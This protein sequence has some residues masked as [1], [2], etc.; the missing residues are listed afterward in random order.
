MPSINRG[1]N[2]AAFR[3]GNAH[4]STIANLKADD[5]LVK[6]ADSVGLRRLLEP[7]Y[8]NLPAIQVQCAHFHIPRGSGSL[9]TGKELLSRAVS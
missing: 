2:R 5:S 4:D 7:F 1:P 6:G 9:C 3:S 8:L